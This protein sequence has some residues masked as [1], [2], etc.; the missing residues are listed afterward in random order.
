MVVHIL[1]P[2]CS[3]DLAEIYPFY[4]LVKNA[5]CEKLLKKNDKFPIHPD[6]MDFKSDI[7]ENFAFILNALHINKM[8]CR[9]HILG[10]TEFDSL[11]D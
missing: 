8:C 10:N 7:L 4:I 2:E 1:C 6:K 3:E 9:V 5:Y 11:Y